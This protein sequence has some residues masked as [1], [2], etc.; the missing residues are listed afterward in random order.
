MGVGSA[1]GL[2]MLE[3]GQQLVGADIAANRQHRMNKELQE[4][5]HIYNEESAENADKRTRA[6]YTDFLSPE[7]R[8]KQYKEAGLNP[9]LMYS[10]GAAAGGGI[11]ATGAQ[12]T[13]GGANGAGLADTRGMDIAGIMQ[14]Q[15]SAE[16]L[17]A[18]AEL[19][20]EEAKR[21][22]GENPLGA[23]E[24]N[25]NEWKAEGE[26]QKAEKTHLE[27]ELVKAQT[28][29]AN[30]EAWVKEN[31][32]EYALDKLKYEA[33][34]T[35]EAFRSAKVKAN[36]DE[37]TEQYLT[38]REELINKKYFLEALKIEVETDLTQTQTE[39]AWVGMQEL[40]RS[41]NI[42]QLVADRN[43]E[44]ALKEIKGKL[45]AAGIDAGGSILETIIE[46]AAEFIPG[47]KILKKV[48]YHQSSER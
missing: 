30:A 6:L 28:A 19:K 37:N 3:W 17:K 35:R 26:K 4:Q 23:S 48:V 15:A 31:G 8:V 29:I 18:D 38:E 10:G 27:Q 43:Y 46:I 44:V 25:L 39:A 11:G 21:L 7:A 16:N 9:A 33:W 13:T 34:G 42:K 24:I 41:N 20:R 47:A 14:T 1:V 32:K 40:V 45:G 36:V 2:G 22:R 12:A 5:Q